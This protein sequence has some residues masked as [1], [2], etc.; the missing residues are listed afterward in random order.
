MAATED[1]VIALAGFIAD[2]LSDQHRAEEGRWP[3]KI[4]NSYQSGQNKVVV[5]TECGKI[6]MIRVT[7]L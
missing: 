6:F 4:E 3:Y 1:M 7:D 2:R 5:E